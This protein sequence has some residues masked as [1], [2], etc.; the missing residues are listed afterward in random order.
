MSRQRQ[1]L[2]GYCRKNRNTVKSAFRPPSCANGESRNRQLESRSAMHSYIWDIQ[3]VDQRVAAVIGAAAAIAVVMN[4]LTGSGRG[5]GCSPAWLRRLLVL[6]VGGSGH[7][8]PF[9]ARACVRVDGVNRS[10]Q[11]DR[12][13]L[14]RRLLRT[15]LE[16]V[17]SILSWFRESAL[18]RGCVRGNNTLSLCLFSGLCRSFFTCDVDAAATSWLSLSR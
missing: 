7:W 17:K 13:R 6:P 4:Y 12:T 1:V 16:S 3:P 10:P 8:P 11:G 9:R 14:R 15:H 2:I 5:G 18:R